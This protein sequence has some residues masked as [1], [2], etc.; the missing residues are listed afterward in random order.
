MGLDTIPGIDN[1]K[2]LKTFS[3]CS[4]LEPIEI[5]ERDWTID[6]M[7]VDLENV[8]RWGGGV[9]KGLEQLKAQTIHETVKKS[10]KKVSISPHGRF[11]SDF[12]VGV[13][14]LLEALEAHRIS[15][16]VEFDISPMKIPKG[17]V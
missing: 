7:E 13:T 12:K 16:I 6:T 14:L 5:L 10:L 11:L 15:T 1:Y 4:K 9:E 3:L 17:N 8:Y 2:A